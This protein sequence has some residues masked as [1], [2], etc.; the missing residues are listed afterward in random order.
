[1]ASL[2]L[3]DVK[4]EVED[5]QLACEVQLKDSSVIF[6]FNDSDKF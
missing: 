6:C 2:M 1:M 4:H 3:V 5:F